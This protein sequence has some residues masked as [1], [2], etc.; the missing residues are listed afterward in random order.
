MGK[1]VPM[2]LFEDMMKGPW[3]AGLVGAGVALVAPTVLPVVG[4]ALRPLA[5]GAIRAGVMVYDTV[6]EA[7]AEAGEEVSNMVTEVRAETAVRGETDEE[8]D[9]IE[10]TVR[11]RG[12]SRRG[13]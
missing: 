12:R 13:A 6:Q 4:A 2:S 10:G 7:V 11:R 9:E 8:D 1:E 3:G 5:M